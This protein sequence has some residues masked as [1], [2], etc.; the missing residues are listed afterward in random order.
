MLYFIIYLL[1]QPIFF[2]VQQI[3]TQSSDENNQDNAS[4]KETRTA[5]DYR[6]THIRH[7]ICG[8]ELDLIMLSRLKVE[9][10]K[11]NFLFD[12]GATISLTKLK[13]LKGN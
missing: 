12:I 11:I 4:S 10:N 1:Q 5:A 7:A 3:H 9:R 8:I 6:V 13:T 2:L